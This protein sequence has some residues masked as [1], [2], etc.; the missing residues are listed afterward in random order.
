[1]RES[2]RMLYF[3]RQSRRDGGLTRPR[4]TRTNGRVAMA[5]NRRFWFAVMLSVG[6]LG[7]WQALPEAQSAPSAPVE[8]P[9]TF[10]LDPAWPKPLPNNWGL[11]MVWGVSVD[12]RDHIWV[13]HQIAG[14]RYSEAIAKAGK[15]PAP[16][17]LEFD[18]QGN[19]L[20]AWG[21]PG[22][23]GWAQGKDRPFPAQQIKIDWK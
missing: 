9:P 11:G 6:A 14:Q 13:V 16:A 1:M 5:K 4:G 23:G 8:P 20:Q 17:V 2:S 12:A 21:V 15:V 3:L 19:L 10:E 22:Q 7:A 18:Q